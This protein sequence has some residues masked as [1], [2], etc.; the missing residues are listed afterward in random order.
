MGYRRSI[1]ASLAL[2]LV[3]VLTHPQVGDTQ[4]VGV[5]FVQVQ[6]VKTLD[7]PRHHGPNF[8]LQEAAE[9]YGGKEFAENSLIVLTEGEFFEF[10][11]NWHYWVPPFEDTDEDG[12]ALQEEIRA[13]LRG[14]IIPKM[15]TETLADRGGGSA[16]SYHE[17]FTDQQLKKHADRSRIRERTE[18]DQFMNRYYCYVERARARRSFVIVLKELLSRNPLLTC[19][20]SSGRLYLHLLLALAFSTVSTHQRTIAPPVLPRVPRQLSRRRPRCSVSAPTPASSLCLST[21]RNSPRRR[22]RWRSRARAS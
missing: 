22:R 17:Q 21:S 19:F 12:A 6:R 3:L 15:A 11:V 13:K 10:G 16:G 14:R 9:L 18:Y 2:E 1:I 7:I 5:Q 20:F 4:I 8:A